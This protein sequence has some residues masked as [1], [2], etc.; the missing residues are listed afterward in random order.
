[1]SIRSAN[2]NDI[3]QIARIHASRFPTQFVGRLPCSLLVKFYAAQLP[4]SILLVHDGEHG[5]DGFVH[6]G[7]PRLMAAG[8]KAFL[9]ASL[10]RC[11]WH[12]ATQPPLCWAAIKSRVGWRSA[13]QQSHD[14]PSEC[15]LRCLAVDRSAEGMG[16][17]TALI[18]AFESSIRDRHSSYYLWVLKDNSRAIRLYEKSGFERRQEGPGS[19][20]LVKRLQQDSSRRGA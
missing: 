10:G 14:I 7:D 8:R 3:T 4:R 17:G 5:V 16:I 1:M 12:M 20:A 15:C 13:R 11:L 18:E 19:V 9:W 2:A 6:G